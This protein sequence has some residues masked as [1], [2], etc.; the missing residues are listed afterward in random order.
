[1]NQTPES[2]QKNIPFRAKLEKKIKNWLKRTKALHGE[3]RYVAMGMAVGIFVSATPTIPFQTLIAVAICLV[4]R[5]SK[6]AAAVGVWLSNPLTIPLFYLGSYKTGAMLLGISND[7]AITSYNAADML[8]LGVDITVAAVAG[9][10]MIGIILGVVAYFLTFRAVTKIRSREKKHRRLHGRRQSATSPSA[11][12]SEPNGSAE[13]KT[14]DRRQKSEVREQNM[15][16]REHRTTS[17]RKMSPAM[18]SD[19]NDPACEYSTTIYCQ[20]VTKD[21]RPGT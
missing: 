5:G 10:I 14:E 6:T 3:P 18:I 17:G 20:P 11:V 12:S 13:A 7:H 16:H 2:D 4:V 9:G 21:Q 15:Q 19:P 8:E 1:M